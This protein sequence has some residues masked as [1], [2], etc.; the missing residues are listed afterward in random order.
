MPIEVLRW[1]LDLEASRPGEPEAARELLGLPPD[2]PVVASV[3]GLSRIYNP[4]LLLEAFAEVHS[5]DPMRDCCS[6]I[7]TRAC[8]P[9]STR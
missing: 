9:R 8:R 2:G 6:S 3:R 5:D 7:R 1:G 4:E